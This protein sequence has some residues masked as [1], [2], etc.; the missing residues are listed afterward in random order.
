MNS[1]S[2]VLKQNNLIAANY[3]ISSAVGATRKVDFN[4]SYRQDDQ[5]SSNQ[6][7]TLPQI[8]RVS[9]RDLGKIETNLKKLLAGKAIEQSPGLNKVA[10]RSEV[11]AL[12][13]GSKLVGSSLCTDDDSKGLLGLDVGTDGPATI[14]EQ[15]EE[16]T[17]DQQSINDELQTRR[18]LGS[19][20]SA[21]R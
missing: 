16:E 9:S 8:D 4:P 7:E 5:L 18:K 10:L 2:P 15:D 1:S 6:S 17:K 20:K 11:R 12:A 19:E 21:K 13:K 3:E 14:T